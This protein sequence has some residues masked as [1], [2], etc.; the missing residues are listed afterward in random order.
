MWGEVSAAAVAHA[1]PCACPLQVKN[2][3]LRG[4]GGGG[5][6]SVCVWRRESSVSAVVAQ[7]SLRTVWRCLQAE[8]WEHKRRERERRGSL[9]CDSHSRGGG[10]VDAAKIISSTAA[11]SR[12]CSGL[13]QTADE[14]RHLKYVIS[15]KALNRSL[16]SSQWLLWSF[17]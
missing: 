7:V 13:Q 5:G 14:Q 6:E 2:Y 8:E 16:H 15:Q 17:F 1:V 10:K 11:R 3:V 12:K 9:K 4:G